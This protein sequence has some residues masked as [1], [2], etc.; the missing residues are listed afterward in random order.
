MLVEVFK[1]IVHNADEQIRASAVE[2]G[3]DPGKKVARY[4]GSSPRHPATSGR[5]LTRL[6]CLLSASLLSASLFS[7]RGSSQAPETAEL[8]A[9]HEFKAG[10]EQKLMS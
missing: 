3:R 8:V 9:H 7:A 1:V 10:R 5:F 2:N 6:G 4:G